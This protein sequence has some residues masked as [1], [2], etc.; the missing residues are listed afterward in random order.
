MVSACVNGRFH[1][2][3]TV[4]ASIA[5]TLSTALYPAL[6]NTGM[7]RSCPTFTVNTR[8]SVVSGWPSCQVTFGLIRHVVSMRPSGSSFHMPFSSVGTLSASWG[9]SRP[10]AFTWAS[11]AL[12]ISSSASRPGVPPA[13]ARSMVLLRPEGSPMIA[14]VIRFG[15][16]RCGCWAAGC[17]EELP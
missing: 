6:P 8:S 3:V 2:T 4:R 15:P 12:T 9:W 1:R 14:T 17:D 11:P 13:P 10:L 5:S 7:S 16:V